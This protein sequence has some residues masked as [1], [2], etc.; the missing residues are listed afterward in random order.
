M[1]TDAEGLR[2]RQCEDPVI[3][4]ANW[5]PVPATYEQQSSFG[6]IRLSHH[7]NMQRAR[8][9]SPGRRYTALWGG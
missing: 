7:S 4:V 2:S 6:A 9:C 8:A 5:L 3:V 1:G